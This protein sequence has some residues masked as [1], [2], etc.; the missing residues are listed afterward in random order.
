MI[1]PERYAKCRRQLVNL[2]QTPE[3]RREKYQFCRAAGANSYEAM[4][5][6]DWRWE[7]IHEFFQNVAD[8]EKLFKER[9]ESC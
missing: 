5:M 7:Y 6:K 8:T 9:G 4:R 1:V 3:E 2:W